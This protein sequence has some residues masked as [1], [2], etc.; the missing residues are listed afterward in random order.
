MSIFFNS[1][2]RLLKSKVQIAVLFI[3]PF[4]PLIPICLDNSNSMN[5]IKVGIIDNDRTELTTT[6][7]E[8]LK[9]VFKIVNVKQENIYDDINNSKADY[10]LVI[11]KGYTDGIIN[12]RNVKLN[13]YVKRDKN[14]T[15]IMQN[16]IDN[17]VN[18]VKNI[19][20][21]SNKDS[22]R[23]YEGLNVFKEK[24]LILSKSSEEKPIKKN[25]NVV[26]GMIIQFVMFSSV[27]T[28]TLIITDK[29]NKTLFRTLNTGISLRN[30]MLQTILSFF[31]LS[32]LQTAVLVAVTVY[33]FNEPVGVSIINMLLL[34]S[35][36]SLVSVSFGIAVSSISKN[37]TQA[38]MIGIGTV[39]FMS[40]V[41]GA[42]GMKTSS[43]LI[44]IISKLMPVTW[45][46]EAVE[47]LLHNEALSSITQ[48]I[49]VLLIFVVI[50]FLLG[51]WKK[52]EITK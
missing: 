16:F 39:T 47:K 27:F 10:I 33:G 17:F 25:A 13:G 41:G 1:L 18:P 8:S 43:E 15:P 45:A 31:L 40:M 36:L 2:K 5:T 21:A 44:K 14:L 26:F 23:F 37:L 50:F 51:T 42:W 9:S 12:Y 35:I 4:I 24:A 32:L 29:E 11:P 7:Q 19:A 30:Y 49:F 52:A 28:A 20:L 48:N 22:I 6:F 38:I 46:M 34:L 3:L